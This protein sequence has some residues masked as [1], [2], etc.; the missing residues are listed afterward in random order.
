MAYGKFQ[1][2]TEKDAILKGDKRVK[3]LTILMKQREW[4]R[5]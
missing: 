5:E 2:R 4:D 3:K 1:G